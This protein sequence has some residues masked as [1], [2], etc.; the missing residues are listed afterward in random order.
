VQYTLEAIWYAKGSDRPQTNF[1]DRT[2]WVRPDWYKPLDYNAEEDGFAAYCVIDAIAPGWAWINEVNVFGTY[3]RQYENTDESRQFVEI[4]H[5]AEVDLNGWHVDLLS[6]AGGKVVT[7]RI[8]RFGWDVPKAKATDADGVP[9]GK[10]S[11]MVFRA[12]ACPLAENTDAIRIENGTADAFWSWGKETGVSGSA[13][14]DYDKDVLAPSVPCGVRLVRPTGIIEHEI[15]FTGV[16]MGYSGVAETLAALN[17]ASPLASFFS[18]GSD[19]FGGMGGGDDA[20]ENP[21][22]DPRMLTSLGVFDARGRT[23]DV[24]NNVMR[25]TPGRI[26][27]GQYIDPDHP[28][29]NGATMCVYARLDRS[30]GHVRQTF[31]N[32]SNTTEDVIAVLKAGEKGTNITYHVDRWYEFAG[33]TVSKGAPTWARV[34]GEYNTY[35]LFNVGANVSNSVEVTAFAKVSRHLEDM[36]VTPDNAYSDAIM[37]WLGKGELLDGTPF[38]DPDADTVS[39]AAFWDP[40]DRPIG[41]LNLTQMYIL[42]MDPTIG[43]DLVLK[44]GV[45]EPPDPYVVY[46]NDYWGAVVST[47]VVIGVDMMISNRADDVAWAPYVLR[48][49]APGE[50]SVDFSG[51]WTGATFKVTGFLA[52]GQTLN[53]DYGQWVPLRWF[54]FDRGSFGFPGAPFRSYIEIADPYGTESPGYWSGWGDWIE[55]NG[56]RPDVFYSWAIDGRIKPYTIEKLRPDSRYGQ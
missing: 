40:Q 25:L 56:W 7:N 2:E 14:C 53:S 28:V 34:P 39:T 5:P 38:A 54:V 22:E 11:N 18:V 30:L 21:D 1:L 3:D 41:T 31:A 24:W 27:E 44:A 17:D 13:F 36:G 12:I 33:A 42:D 23:A 6:V 43:S 47:N 51:T 19:D 49:L 37:D 52:N 9:Y 50:N 48:G 15:L 4:A 10:A 32:Y 20:P 46:T 29:A 16:E 8:A 26:N 55:Q 45:V 35:R